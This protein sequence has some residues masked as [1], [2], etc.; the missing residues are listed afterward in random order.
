M[1]GTP[2]ILLLW[3]YNHCLTTSHGRHGTENRDRNCHA[4]DDLDFE[5]V[6]YCFRSARIPDNA[7]LKVD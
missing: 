1:S 6:V 2:M 5:Y 7:S 4:C 3:F